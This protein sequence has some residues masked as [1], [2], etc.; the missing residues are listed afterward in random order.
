[1][2]IAILGAGAVGSVFGGRLALAGHDV[3]LVV[4]RQ[5]H[6]AALRE[7]GLV[8]R[9]PEGGEEVI[10][11]PATAEP[12]RLAPVQAVIVAV[13]SYATAEAARAVAP[14]IAPDTWVATVQNGLGND[15]VLADVLG[16][17]DHVV[18][19]TTTVSAV[20]HELAVVTMAA[21]TALGNSLT[22]FGPPRGAGAAPV[23]VDRL[24]RAL[25]EAGLPTEV[26]DSA[27]VLVWAKLAMAA[28][29]GPVTALLRRTIGDAVADLDSRL[30]LLELFEEVVAVAH[31]VGVP[32][33][34][35]ETLDHW[36]ATVEAMGG[37]TS[38]M[39]E[40]VQAKRRTEIDAFCGE[41]A[42]RGAQCGVPTPLN[43]TMWRLI[44]MIEATYGRELPAAA[45]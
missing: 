25:T 30:V 21:P 7:R 26:L 15:A 20:Q 33:D 43:R 4:R 9:S 2:R 35:D 24:A 32:L 18:P 6:A 28:S 22:H 37:H 14:A 11:V 29:V 1:M 40:D 39:A 10:A 5:E 23:G 34:H 16:R 19:G 27:D 13:K 31:A 41:V 44:R 8:L 12:A 42:R 38:S 45:P 3:T 36:L 17:R